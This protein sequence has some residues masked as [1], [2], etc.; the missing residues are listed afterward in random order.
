MRVPV[1]VTQND[2]VGRGQVDAKAASASAQHEDEL[3]A[4]WRVVLVN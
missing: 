3:G 4:A 1:G 2:N